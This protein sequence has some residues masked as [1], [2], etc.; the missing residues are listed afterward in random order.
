M[1]SMWLQ[2]TDILYLYKFFFLMICIPHESLFFYSCVLLFFCSFILVFFCSFL[3]FTSLF[4]I[5]S[6]FYF[7]S[8]SVVGVSSMQPLS[9]SSTPLLSPIFSGRKASG[10][11]SYG[12]STPVILHRSR[13]N[14]RFY[15]ENI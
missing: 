3:L 8:I 14:L 9:S 10:N 7:S 12:V 6:S 11:V 4:F 5:F 13:I 2:I 1:I 15:R